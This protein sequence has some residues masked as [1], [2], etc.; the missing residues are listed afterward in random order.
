MSQ[1]R[2][3]TNGPRW[4]RTALTLFCAAAAL[5]AI[6]PRA[7]VRASPDR[8]W[9]GAVRDT[10]GA[11][12]LSVTIRST[13]ESSAVA[14]VDFPDV[15]GYARRFTVTSTGSKLHLERG[16]P[17]SRAIVLDAYVSAD[18]MIGTF[19]GLGV[20]APFVLRRT[21]SPPR[22][23]VESTT[24]A[25]G[26]IQLAGSIYRPA[27]PGS[28]PAVVEIH[29]GGPDTRA[30]Y[31]SKAIFLAR[32][33]ITTLI[34][35]KRGT[36][37]SSGDWET[38]SMEDLARDALAGV[39]MLRGLT[40]VNPHRVGVEGFSQGGW[41]APLAAALD[42]RVAFVVVG[43]ASGINP[44]DQ[45]IYQVQNE[46]RAARDPDSV[47]QLATALRK[48]L[49]AAPRGE[50]RRALSDELRH[51]RATPWFARSG[52]PDSLSAS[53]PDGVEAFLHF[54]PEPVWRRIHV[55]VL[56]YW[57][58]MDTNLPAEK[59]RTIIAHALSAAG[60]ADTSFVIYPGSSHSMSRPR[61]HA[62]SE[63]ALPRV[64]PSYELIAA[65][66]KGHT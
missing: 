3:E 26:P 13:S 45:S 40:Y 6:S 4:R 42:S 22:V 29:G 62:T 28:H 11:W 2:E 48:R 8:T 54:E 19:A 27:A 1:A 21:E 20:T 46:M 50:S 52:L 64:Y 32:H 36:G 33:G 35:D 60:D 56:A 9:A 58:G 44:M 39:T 53:I 43:S 51:L 10:D 34:Y 57:G 47:V 24:F 65:W 61:A 31:E 37:Q 55:P 66:L 41:I 15:D 38:A 49:Y 23:V 17:N 14:D 12:K 18:R 7:P 5:G 59:S 63:P 16:Q 30:N 25:D